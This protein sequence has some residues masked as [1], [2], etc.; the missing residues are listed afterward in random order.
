MFEVKYL[1]YASVPQGVIIVGNKVA[2]MIWSENPIAFVIESEKV[3]K[4]YRNFFN[5]LWMKARS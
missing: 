5:E 2:T 1:N 4:S 3:S